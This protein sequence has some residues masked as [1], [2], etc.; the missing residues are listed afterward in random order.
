MSKL[1]K[2]IPSIDGS[3]GVQERLWVGYNGHKV[4]VVTH[5]V[6]HSQGT[7]IA[8]IKNY[9]TT[10]YQ[11]DCGNQT[12]HSGKPK[13]AT[14]LSHDS[15]STPEQRAK[16]DEILKQYDEEDKAEVSA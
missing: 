8:K 10:Q 11:C 15:W 6:T 9:C 2:N 13:K 4:T 7:V 3:V 1:I 16:L 12:Q 14:L 5:F